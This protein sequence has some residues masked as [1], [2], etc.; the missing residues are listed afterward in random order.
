MKNK[1]FLL[2]DKIFIYYIRLTL[3]FLIAFSIF[4][5]YKLI[6]I[7]VN[8]DNF[9]KELIN[10]IFFALRIYSF[11]FIIIQSIIIQ[12]LL[13]VIIKKLNPNAKYKLRVNFSYADFIIF[14][15]ANFQVLLLC[16]II[17]IKVFKY[18]YLLIN[19]YAIIYF[20]IS[21]RYIIKARR[22]FY[23]KINN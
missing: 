14:W 11:S 7:N 22:I 23:F 10:F 16:A 21:L 18:E 13:I 6:C 20:L 12:G 15:V 2:K 17:S 4:Q 9:R 19:A 5:L 8:I 3:F 1:N